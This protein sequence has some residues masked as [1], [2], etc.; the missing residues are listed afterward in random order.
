M[1]SLN[2]LLVYIYLIILLNI[3]RSAVKIYE[4]INNI[5]INIR[6][7]NWFIFAGRLDTLF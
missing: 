2:L 4:K 5:L 6:S 7:L 1:K 3:T